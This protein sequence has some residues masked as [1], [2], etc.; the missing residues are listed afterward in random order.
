MEKYLLFY[1]WL[2]HYNSKKDDGP[3]V[4]SLWI[5]T[6]TGCHQKS[7]EISSAGRACLHSKPPNCAGGANN[8]YKGRFHFDRSG[9]ASA[10]PLL[11]YAGCAG[12]CQTGWNGS[13]P[14][15]PLRRCRP[16][17]SLFLRRRIPQACSA[18][19]SPGAPLF[20]GLPFGRN[21]IPASSFA[22]TQPALSKPIRY[23][24]PGGPTCRVH[25]IS[26][27]SF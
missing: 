3:V 18:A 16:A 6:R 25:R 4:R 23:P 15:R 21:G 12:G 8:P 10:A 22:C 19:T 24:L 27:C 2:L 9:A 1:A 5:H 14:P 26:F 13:S 17:A 20:P 11:F 7:P